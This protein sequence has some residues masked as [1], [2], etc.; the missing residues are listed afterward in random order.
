MS[1]KNGNGRLVDAVGYLRR[2][3][4]KQ[5]ASIPDQQTAVQR[6]ADE[7][8]YRIIRWYI[9]D[10]VSGDDT[11]KRHDFLRMIA[12]AG[13]LRDFQAILC[14]DGARFGRF[15]SIEAGYYIFPLRKAGVYLATVMEGVTDWNDSTGRIVGNVKQEGKHQ[16]LIDLSANV[17]RGQLE[18]AKNAS[19]IGSPPYAYKIEG[20]RK[21]KRLV[22]GDPGQVCVVQ[23]I[24]REFVEEGRAMMNIA[25]RLNKDGIV[26]PSGRVKGWRFDTI[27]V[28]L[29]NPAYAGDYAGCRYSYGKYHTIKQG[30]VAKAN[31]RCSRPESEW[32][33]R[34]DSHEPIVDRAT[35]EKAQAILD[36]GK[37]G[38]SPYTP[39]KNP[40]VL[41]GLLRCGRCGAPLGGIHSGSHVQNN[42]RRYYECG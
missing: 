27:R 41:A 32:V 38:R 29:R 40:F 13:E 23:R 34:R 37:T 3:T 10:A 19:W 11:G 33:V 14:W 20:P 22:L 6:Y 28:I 21:H 24:F 18:A 36:K 15:D 12:D 4:D 8:G 16:Q 5:E 39:E 42:R 26:S 2:S 31:G 30:T 9:D 35:W 7:R 17:T 25:T 1:R